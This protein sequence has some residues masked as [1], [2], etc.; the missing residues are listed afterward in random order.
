MTSLPPLGRPLPWTNQDIVLYHGTVDRFL[1]K[2]KTGINVRAGSIR[3]DFGQG[4]YTTTL[5]R[6]ARYWAWQVSQ[7]P[8][9]PVGSQPAV[10]SFKVGRE[11]LARLD[12]LW[13]ER[14]LLR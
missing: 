8:G 10:I 9:L 5:E 3:T 6:Q 13:Y 7:Q 12:S 4:F 11:D 2:I 14:R 1:S